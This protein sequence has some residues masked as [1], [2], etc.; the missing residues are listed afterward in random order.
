MDIIIPE[1]APNWPH[2]MQKRIAEGTWHDV[3]VLAQ[4][5]IQDNP[6]NIYGYELIVFIM[7]RMW[8]F[9][10]A[11]EYIQQGLQRTH[12]NQDYLY[13]LY[14]LLETH[15][16]PLH[17]GLPILNS[18]QLCREWLP[19][20]A[21]GTF[22][23]EHTSHFME[24]ITSL[25]AWLNGDI[26]Y[27]E[28][29]SSMQ[30]MCDKVKH[31]VNHTDFTK[32]RCIA[33]LGGF[34]GSTAYYLWRSFP[35]IEKI[36][37]VDTT[38]PE[39]APDWFREHDVPI[40][41]I[42]ADILNV[43]FQQ[44]G[45]VDT[46]FLID[47]VEHIPEEI[48]EQIFSTIEEKTDQA[49]IFIYTPTLNHNTLQ[50]FERWMSQIELSSLNFWIWNGMALSPRTINHV[51]SHLSYKSPGWLFKTLNTL[52]YKCTGITGINHPQTN[53]GRIYLT[54]STAIQENEWQCLGVPSGRITL[55]I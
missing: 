23:E 10:S 46:F 13:Y 53:P 3:L 35:N 21:V 25:H 34:D 11:A 38:F 43:D 17:E 22:S 24:D 40:E 5:E 55:R 7:M 12:G 32:S 48:C 36:Y 47:V 39:E 6:Q 41:F 2:D 50:P 52:G 14:E 26:E 19:A 28:V 37:L 8:L 49:R 4:Q 18:D 27:N 29:T 9:L 51:V 16:I 45:E 1:S 44:F 33:D 54:A 15:T 42:Q 31:A 30:T 20:Q